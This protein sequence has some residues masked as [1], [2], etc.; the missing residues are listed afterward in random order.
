MNIFT[1]K[2][3]TQRESITKEYNL[4]IVE[5]KLREIPPQTK[6]LF[7]YEEKTEELSSPQI[8]IFIIFRENLG[9]LFPW[10]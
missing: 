2:E 8:E 4:V 5:G 7:I 6:V 1:N 10:S 9:E 3:V